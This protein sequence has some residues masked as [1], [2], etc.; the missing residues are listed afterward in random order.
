MH[1]LREKCDHEQGTWFVLILHPSSFFLYRLASLCMRT[2]RRLVSV[3]NAFLLIQ[4]LT[5]DG[6]S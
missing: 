2:Q 1:V 5:A 3:L 4:R 6:P